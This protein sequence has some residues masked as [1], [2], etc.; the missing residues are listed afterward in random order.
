VCRRANRLL[1]WEI[2]SFWRG[3]QWNKILLA[4]WCHVPEI[5]LTS[6]GHPW[7]DPPQGGDGFVVFRAIL[8]L[9]HLIFS[10]CVSPRSTVSFPSEGME[11][12]SSIARQFGLF[13]AFES[14]ACGLAPPSI[15]G[16][17]SGLHI[18]ESRAFRSSLIYPV[19]FHRRRANRH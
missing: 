3:Q 9:G 12:T 7:H 13:L 2:V 4:I 11:T 17:A 16:M 15:A 8:F 6:I 14:P 5:N 19:C 1:P 18:P 10:W